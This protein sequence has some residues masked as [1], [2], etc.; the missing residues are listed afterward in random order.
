MRTGS[1]AKQASEVRGCSEAAAVTA[2][3]AEKLNGGKKRLL[4]YSSVVKKY[5][6]PSLSPVSFEGA[7]MGVTG[8]RSAGVGSAM[9]CHRKAGGEYQRSAFHSEPLLSL[10]TDIALG[11][12]AALLQPLMDER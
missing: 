10:C 11:E 7:A 4:L 8:P 2:K 6:S 5:P 1:Q 9:Q 3:Q 12:E